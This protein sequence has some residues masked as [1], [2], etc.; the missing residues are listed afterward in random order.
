MEQGILDNEQ[1]IRTREQGMHLLVQGIAHWL[2]RRFKAGAR[3]RPMP[4]RANTPETVERAT[5][6]PSAISKAVI[7]YPRLEAHDYSPEAHYQIH[8]WLRLFVR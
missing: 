7:R 6:G 1:G 3:S 8:P 2:G 5:C 4:W